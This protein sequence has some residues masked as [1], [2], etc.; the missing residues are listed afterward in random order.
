MTASSEQSSRLI[1]SS[2]NEQSLHWLDTEHNR[3]EAHGAGLLQSP[4]DS[5]WYWYGESKK[6][7]YVTPGVNCYSSDSLAGP[8]KY[9]GKVINQSMIVVH[10]WKPPFVV[11]RPK[12]V[13]N[14]KTGVFVMWFHVDVRRE[15]RYLRYRMNNP[16]N[17]TETHINESLLQ[18]HID[19][20]CQE[21]LAAASCGWTMV[22]S[23]PGQPI[24][25]KGLADHD[26]SDGYDCCCSQGHWMQ[27]PKVHYASLLQQGVLDQRRMERRSR[28]VDRSGEYVLRRVGVA[29]ASSP[30]GPWTVVNIFRPDGVAS[31]DLSL[32]V[33]NDGT[34]YFI[35]SCD[36][37]YTG[38]SRLTDDYLQTTGIIS[39][40]P[41]FEGMS[42]F[43]HTNGTLYMMTSHLTGWVPNP[44]ML[45]RN[46]GDSLDDPRWVNL[47]NPTDSLTSFNTQPTYVVQYTTKQGFTYSIYMA[48]NWVHGG[49]EGLEAASYVW[50]PIRFTEDGVISL[51]RFL[52]WDLEDPFAGL[53]DL[54]HL[55][56]NR[57]KERRPAEAPAEALAPAEEAA[58]PAGDA[59]LVLVENYVF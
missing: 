27:D 58:E 32:W 59:T 49:D 44:L 38:I 3:I 50:L 8:W 21:Y 30:I 40:G 1:R 31:L 48:D 9:E 12:V 45:Y 54:L 10:K 28:R 25:K 46:D 22:Y 51:N 43:R 11:E 39:K 55:K 37:A 23:C 33:D 5:R 14:N 53:T 47:G 36:N 57:Q 13:Y 52:E 20:I 29:T 17:F 15:D 26:E 18:E 42:L 16:D 34:A 56:E 24:G 4:V 41:R 6:K 7:D 19:L 35:R 2:F